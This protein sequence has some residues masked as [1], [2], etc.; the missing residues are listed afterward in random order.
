MKPISLETDRQFELKAAGAHES[1]TWMDVVYQG[2][3]EPEQN[4]V[5]APLPT[6]R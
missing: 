3:H 5:C 4:R 1:Q 2:L 6:R